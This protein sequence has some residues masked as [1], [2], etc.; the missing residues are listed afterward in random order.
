ML[1][2]LIVTPHSFSALAE[3]GRTPQSS[4][5]TSVPTPQPTGTTNSD[6]LKWAFD[7]LDALDFDRDFLRTLVKDYPFDDEKRQRIIF[8][9][10]FGFLKRADYTGHYSRIAVQ[11]STDF[12]NQ[13]RSTFARAYQ[14]SQVD[15]RVVAALLWVETKHGKQLGADP[16]GATLLTIIQGEHPSFLPLALD[17]LREREPNPTPEMIEKTVSR[18]KDKAAW[19]TEELRA[20][21]RL[22]KAQGKGVLTWKGSFAGAFGYSQFL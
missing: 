16:I 1:S 9:N 13:Y 22:N 3:E 18:L 19:A 20:F 11:K 7:R 21:R 8:L 10:I 5:A 6:P 15:P 2:L 12:L 4:P 14:H 17:E